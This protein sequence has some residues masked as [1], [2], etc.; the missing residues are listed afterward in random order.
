MLKLLYTIFTDPLG[1]PLTPIWEFIILLI[2]GEIVHE[3]AFYMSPGGDFGSLIYWISKLI[4]FVIIWAVL[5]AVITAIQFVATYWL[6]FVIGGII[7]A[8]GVLIFCRC[9]KRKTRPPK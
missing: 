5:Y 8:I 3:I 7:L 1:L 6:W 2:V 9:K 4:V